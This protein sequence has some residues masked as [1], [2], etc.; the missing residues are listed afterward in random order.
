MWQ[1][2][3]KSNIHLKDL[4]EI[5]DT[6]NYSDGRSSFTLRYQGMLDGLF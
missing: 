4:I 5:F 1:G 2:M 3:D 6:Y